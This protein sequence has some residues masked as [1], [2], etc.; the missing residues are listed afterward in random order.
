LYPL[1]DLKSH[2][3]VMVEIFAR[4]VH[5]RSVLLKEF[6]R[7]HASL[8]AQQLADIRFGQPFGAVSFKDDCFEDRASRLLAIVEKQAFECIWKFNGNGHAL[9]PL[10]LETCFHPSAS[11]Y[12]GQLE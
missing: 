5:E 2:R 7:L 11:G 12:S 8:E 1:C 3:A 6:M 10:G 9:F 4:I